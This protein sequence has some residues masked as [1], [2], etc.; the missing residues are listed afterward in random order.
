MERKICP[1]ERFN[2]NHGAEEQITLTLTEPTSQPAHSVKVVDKITNTS[3]VEGLAEGNNRDVVTNGL[4]TSDLW[5][6]IGTAE[7]CS[8]HPIATAITAAAR[9][10]IGGTWQ[11]LYC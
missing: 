3:A 11:G 8:S 2:C 1:Y 7:A 6:L 5:R 4:T 9:T 10:S